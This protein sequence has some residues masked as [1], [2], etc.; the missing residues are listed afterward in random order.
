MSKGLIEPNRFSVEALVRFSH[1]DPAGIVFYPQYLILANGLKEDWFIQAL[2]I[3]YAE[4]ICSR[5]LGLPTVKLECEFLAPSRIGETLTLSLSV[6]KVG[7]TS[8]TLDVAFASEGER[9]MRMHQV[10]VVTSLDT[11]RP[12]PI[13]EDLRERL[14]RFRGS[15]A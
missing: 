10:V 5:R 12:V 1:C 6:R 8:L 7:N 13:P 2:D 3:P 14:E 4:W 11:H 9:R 15:A